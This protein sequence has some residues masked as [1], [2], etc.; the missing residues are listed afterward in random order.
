VRRIV[1]AFVTVPLIP[2]ILFGIAMGIWGLASPWGFDPPTTHFALIPIWA[3]FALPVSYASAVLLGVPAFLLFRRLGWLSLSRVASGASIIG[4]AIGICVATLF[5][6]T[7]ITFV[8][9]VLVF[10]VFGATTGVAFWWMT[11]SAK[12]NDDV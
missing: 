5:D 1:A 4:L 7:G 10:A 3:M 2:A 9:V 6:F 12:V 11:H 8:V